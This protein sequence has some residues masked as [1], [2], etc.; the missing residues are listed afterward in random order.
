MN[1][2]VDHSGHD[3]LREGGR[4]PVARSPTTSATGTSKFTGFEPPARGQPER[5][6]FQACRM[7]AMGAITIFGFIVGLSQRMTLTWSARAIDTQPAV[8]PM[9]LTCR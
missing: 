1:H 4:S 8:E 3:A 2:N 7:L 6:R 9:P 5:V